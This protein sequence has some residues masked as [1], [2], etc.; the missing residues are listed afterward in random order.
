MNY[1]RVSLSSMKKSKLKRLHTI[2]SNEISDQQDDF[3]FLQWYSAVVDFIESKLYSIRN[4]VK[5][6]QPPKNV[7]KIYFDNKAIEMINLSRILRDKSLDQILPSV[8]NKFTVPMVTYKLSPPIASTI[9]NFKNF[10][11]NLD[12][13]S[14]LLDNSILPCNCQD[15]PFMDPYHKH[16]IS[17]DLNIVADNKLRKLLSKGPNFR[18][19]RPLHW[20]KAR[21]S[22]LSGLDQCIDNYCRD[23]ALNKVTMSPWLYKVTELIDKRIED[24]K[25]KTKNITIIEKLKEP[26]IKRSLKNLHDKFVI[27]PIDK[28]TGNIS[29]ICKRFYADVLIKELGINNNGYNN[30]DTYTWIKNTTTDD[31]VSTHTDNLKKMFNI[32]V[33]DENKCLPSIYWLPKMHK[34]PIKSRFI[35]AAPICSI[36]PLSKSVTSIF[37]MFHQQ[38]ETYNKKCQFF[39]G[40]NTFWVTLNNQPVIRKMNK[41]NLN[42]RAKCITTFDFS[43][44]YTKI[45]HD[46]L[47]YVLNNLIDF[48]FDGGPSDFIA[49]TRF[50][51]QWVDCPTGYKL[52]FD[53]QKVKEAVKFVMMNCY[54]TIGDKI[55]QQIIG[56]PMGSDPAP[57][58]ANLFLYFYESKWL[59]KLQRSDLRRARRFINVFRFID[60]LIALNDDKEFES[61]FKEIY[62]VELEL[63]KENE[64][65]QE[66]TFLDLNIAIK[67]N[68]FSISLYD[69]RDGFPFSIV[70]M[71]YR[72]TNMPS[73]IF[74][75][76]IGAEI[77]RIARATS[78]QENFENSSHTLLTRMMKQGAT[79]DK[80]AKILD[81]VF[82]RHGPCFS[83]FYSASVELTN[84]LL[85]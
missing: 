56:I 57:F 26:S 1:I 32:K 8:P 17:G 41:I 44:L 2:I 31:L 58:F 37:K 66:A 45:P 62:P 20:G 11:E 46:K 35:I 14:Y 36:K 71:P 12:T 79:R 10:V 77:L 16:I 81:K 68:K 6:K 3:L 53:K 50:G 29:F 7:C 21:E 15:S 61:C 9:F 25:V 69:K 73:S 78:I 76:S 54:F 39:T 40:V 51:A 4:N 84:V 49:I 24:L 65:Y 22:L 38:I 85:Q 67:N 27:A 43:T 59:R 75:S 64:G 23:N 83:K 48:C 70:R 5:K 74:Y 72:S 60:D 34:N 82:G 47:L 28:A 13:N 19:S 80:I 33:N 52:I 55:F 42:K 63:G 18:E 30:S